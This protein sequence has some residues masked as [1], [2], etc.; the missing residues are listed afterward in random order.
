MG[1][2]LAPFSLEALIRSRTAILALGLAQILTLAIPYLFK[3]AIDDAILQN[4]PSLLW[5]LA[6]GGIGLHL[7]ATVLAVWGRNRQIAVAEEHRYRLRRDL[8]AQIHRLSLRQLSPWSQGELFSRIQQ[9]TYFVKGLVD[10]VVP[11]LVRIVIGFG[12]SFFVLLWMAPPLLLLSLVVLPFLV[13]LGTFLKH[14]VQPLTRRV[15]KG[16]SQFADAL[17]AMVDGLET[18]KVLNAASQI[19]AEISSKAKVLAEEETQLAQLSQRIAP[20]LG[21]LITSF[22]LLSLAI[23]GHWVMQGS[24]SLGALITYYFYAAMALAPMRNVGSLMISWQQYREATRRVLSL[25]ELDAKPN[26]GRDLSEEV[27]RAIKAK[28]LRFSYPG[29]LQPTLSAL[30]LVAKRGARIAIL[31]PSGAGKSSVVRLLLK[32][33]EPNAGNLEFN[34]STYNS[35]SGEGLRRSIGLVPQ[36]VFLYPGSVA[37]NIAMGAPDLS[38]DAIEEAVRLACVDVFTS[39]VDGGLQRLV[40]GS[41]GLSGG[42]KKRVALAR[43]LV[44]QPQLLIIDQ[45]A[46]DLE[47]DLCARI[48]DNLRGLSMTII[49]LGHRVP[50]GFDA[51]ELFRLERGVLQPIEM[52]S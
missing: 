1:I 46:S 40:G 7:F 5:W 34:D 31:G 38:R 52:E 10:N 3:I 8:V 49:Y 42:Q 23:G 19:E 32:L 30:N 6:L 50:A 33:F 44:A 41:G 9:D 45:L 12:L 37:E 15:L 13:G 26:Q 27:L 47:D 43:A 20:I 2:S 51:T 39:E 21:L 4:R 25:M 24:L 11:A 48:F 22:L 36:E 18:T 35:L 28:S 17:I 14:R 29:S 16:H